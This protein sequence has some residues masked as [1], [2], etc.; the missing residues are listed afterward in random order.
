MPVTKISAKGT[1][2][3]IA[4]T[5]TPT[6]ELTELQSIGLDQGERDQIDMT[7]HSST[8]TE[9]FTDSGLRKTVGISGVIF[10]DPADT[11]HEL[12]RAAHAAGTLVYAT[13]VL[14]DAG[15][16]QWACSG[17]VTAFSIPDRGPKDPLIAN[18]AIKA[19]TAETFTV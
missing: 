14:P 16:A 15:N 17:Y 19:K 12:L 3:K 11:I 8:V 5:A 6:T 2:L 4:L 10:Y 18:F 9:E 7:S 1:K 13:L